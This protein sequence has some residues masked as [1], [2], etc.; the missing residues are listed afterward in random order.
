MISLVT[1][2]AALGGA[3]MIAF[4]DPSPLRLK[5]ILTMTA[6]SLALTIWMMRPGRWQRIARWIVPAFAIAALTAAV[7]IKTA[8][9]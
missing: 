9:G 1:T 6:L 2:P 5:V 8:A 4:P 3:S 7:L